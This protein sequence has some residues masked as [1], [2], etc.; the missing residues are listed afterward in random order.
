MNP[1]PDGFEAGLTDV[2]VGREFSRLVL[3]PTI[4]CCTGACLE[5]RWGRINPWEYSA[6]RHANFT[7]LASS[8]HKSKREVVGT[9]HSLF[10]CRAKTNSWL[11]CCN[12]EGH[13]LTFIPSFKHLRYS[14]SCSLMMDGAVLCTSSL[15]FWAPEVAFLTVTVICETKVM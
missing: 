15:S 5:P 7:T 9:K 1:L 4:F 8:P 2:L 12:T 6:G 13:S 3:T 10:L 11:V 14:S